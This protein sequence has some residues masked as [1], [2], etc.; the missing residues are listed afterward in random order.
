LRKL[1][2]AVSIVVFGSSAAHAA[3]APQLAANAFP[4][5]IA[6]DLQAAIEDA[7]TLYDLDPN[8][9]AAMAFKESAFNPRAVSRRGAQGILQLMP[10]TARALGVR[11]S[12]D[13]RENVFGGARYVRELLDRFNGD[14]DLTLASY[15]LGPERITRE[16]KA[17]TPGVVK[18]V[19]DIKAYYAHA[20]RA[21]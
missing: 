20:L 10:R 6:G 1:V 8:L 7:A 12:F 11:D 14:L 9:L 15:N 3:S 17:A 13:T 16:G 19:G 2:F 21:L 4:A 18:Y 5:P